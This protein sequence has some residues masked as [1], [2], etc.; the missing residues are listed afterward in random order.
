MSEVKWEK[1]QVK[2]Y[3]KLQKKYEG[4]PI[5]EALEDLQLAINEVMNQLGD[6]N[7]EIIKKK[8]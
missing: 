7:Y 6:G 1:D 3:E 2:L 5:F 4:N 8:K